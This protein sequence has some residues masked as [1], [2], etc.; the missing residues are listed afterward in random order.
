MKKKLPDEP[1]PVKDLMPLNVGRVYMD[2]IKKDTT[3]SS[4]GLI[5]LM[6]SCS[7]GQLGALNAESFCERILSCANII[8]TEGNTLLSDEEL[9]MLVVL[10]IN[11]DFMNFMRKEYKEW[12]AKNGYEFGE[13]KVKDG[14][15]VDKPAQSGSS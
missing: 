13:S 6:A 2:L 10:R 11:K 7:V 3:Q 1:D 4:Y 12:G 14:T 8:M 5:P 15:R 9:E